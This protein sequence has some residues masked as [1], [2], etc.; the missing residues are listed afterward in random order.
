MGDLLGWTGLLLSACATAILVNRRPSLGIVLAC[1]FIA[2]ATAALV[3][4]Y[5]V[6]LPGG[7]A[8]AVNFELQA[9]L[10]GQDGLATALQN[11]PGISS[12]TYAWLM[13]LLYAS[14]DRSLL[15]LQATS[16]LAGVV[17]VYLTW[18][19]AHELWNERAAHK[20]AWVMALFPMVVQYSA[21]TMREPWVVVFLLLGLLGVLRWGRTGG[22]LPVLSAVGA[23]TIGT[24]FHGGMFIAVVAF[25]GVIAA[26]SLRQWLGGITRGRVRAVAAV[27]LVASVLVVT[28]VVL[29]G[30]SVPK[31]G[32]AAEAVD[33]ATW[34]AR[35]ESR[36]ANEDAGA[37]YGA[38]QIPGNELDLLWI[39]PM[40]TVY[41]L[42]SPFPW[43]VRTSKHVVG[44]LDGILYIGIGFFAWRNRKAVRSDSGARA[45]FLVVF[46]VVFTFGIG[47]GN[48]GTAM[49]HR[50]KLVAA[51]LCLAAPCLP[52]F[53]WGKRAGF[54]YAKRGR[55]GI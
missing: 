48:F 12:Y 50:S 29:S 44:L 8:D 52:R 42:F 4:Y 53:V 32:T 5:L 28:S 2:R 9:W 51:F 34:V 22:L 11:F 24:F 41:F 38:W 26:S 30:V 35:F 46:T 13:S 47:T 6:P 20:A 55:F 23:F 49:R 31:L 1:A 37:R 40:K 45:V 27:G 54:A 39:A 15:M 17:G 33:F 7:R 14:F 43:D 36:S 21:L 10:W 16:V 3:H 19:L 25:L 18:R